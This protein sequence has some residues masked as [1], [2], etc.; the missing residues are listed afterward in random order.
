[1]PSLDS[2]SYKID[3]FYRIFCYKVRCCLQISSEGD[4]NL[5][6]NQ[7]GDWLPTSGGGSQD[8]QS[9]T[10]AG[11][12]TTNE[13]ISNLQD[14]ELALRALNYNNLETVIIQSG[15]D[16]GVLEVLSYD[17]VDTYIV[18][19]S[20]LNVRITTPN[21]IKQIN[22][23]NGD[24]VTD[25]FVTRVNGI[26]PDS[27]GNVITD[28]V[29]VP[30]NLV[31]DSVTTTFTVAHGQS[32][33]PAFIGSTFKNA[34]AASGTALWLTWDATNINLNFVTPPD[35]GPI[36]IDFLIKF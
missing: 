17:G 21:N 27:T 12:T 20:S 25:T 2:L 10:D 23:P 36:G 35:A 5:F 31:G 26:S 11:N 4:E 14:G 32:S 24:S 15:G 18:D 8:L 6:L 9:V 7:Q 33:I 30:L 28:V 22:F 19:Y 34:V 13:I 3:N 16:G 29:L 1:M